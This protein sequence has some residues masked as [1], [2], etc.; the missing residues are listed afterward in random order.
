MYVAD[1]IITVIMAS[2]DGSG[3]D[4][5]DTQEKK[6]LQR[7]GD[8]M[9]NPS[10]SSTSIEDEY[11]RNEA[12]LENRHALETTNIA[13]PAAAAWE[14]LEGQENPHNWSY[15]KRAYASSIPALMSLVV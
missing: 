3:K 1:Q 6:E 11:K 9:N 4:P 12:D 15:W 7:S 5:I 8:N 14:I 13:Q 10:I 2:S